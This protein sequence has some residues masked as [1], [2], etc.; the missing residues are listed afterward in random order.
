MDIV[1]WV[2][3]IHILTAVFWA[4]GVIMLAWFINPA[5]MASGPQG[6]GFMRELTQGTRMVLFLT[7][8]SYLAILSGF[9]LYWVF[10]GGL[11]PEW[12]SSGKGIAETIGGVAAVGAFLEGQLVARPATRR[13]GALG[14]EIQAGGGTPNEEQLN[15]MMGLQARITRGVRWTAILLIIAL[16]GMAFGRRL[17]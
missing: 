6:Q 5:A 1:A 13:M 9:Y 2:N 16:V 7:L 17:F 3:L 12:F 14:S 4:G 15:R 8:S 11:D 10:S